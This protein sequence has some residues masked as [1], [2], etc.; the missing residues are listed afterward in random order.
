MTFAAAPAL[1]RL[2]GLAVQSEHPTVLNHVVV[3]LI[4][5]AYS[6]ERLRAGC[7]RSADLKDGLAQTQAGPWD[8]YSVV[9]ERYRQGPGRSR[10]FKRSRKSVIV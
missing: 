6:S 9:T 1:R 3:F 10:I 8:V 4:E 5:L 7:C 2:S